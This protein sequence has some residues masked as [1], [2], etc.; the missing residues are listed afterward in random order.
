[1]SAP[2]IS[3]RKKR[4][5]SQ[6]RTATATGRTYRDLG[7]HPQYAIGII[8]RSEPDQISLHRRISTV[9][10]DREVKVLVI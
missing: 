3:N 8:C 1:M 10:G 5:R 6:I 4:Q 2:S 9:A 7:Y